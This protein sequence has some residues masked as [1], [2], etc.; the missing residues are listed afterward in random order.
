MS[1]KVVHCRSHAKHNVENPRDPDELFR[2][3][4]GKGEVGPGEDQGDAEN[5]DEEDNGVGIQ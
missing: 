4:P 3:S 1:R 5:E 2:K